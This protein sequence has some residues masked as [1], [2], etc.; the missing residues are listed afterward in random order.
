[1]GTGTG[2]VYL[3]EKKKPGHNKTYWKPDKVVDRGV[4]FEQGRPVEVQGRSPRDSETDRIRRVS[5]ELQNPWS[6]V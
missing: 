6:E 2:D 5:R 3:G 4:G 1:M